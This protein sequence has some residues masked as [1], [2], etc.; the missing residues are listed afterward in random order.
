MISTVNDNKK[1]TQKPRLEMH[2]IR[3]QTPDRHVDTPY[4]H[5]IHSLANHLRHCNIS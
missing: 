4:T 5:G 2:V 3:R 1:Q